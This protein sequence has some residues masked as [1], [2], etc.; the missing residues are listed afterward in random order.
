MAYLVSLTIALRLNKELTS[1]LLPLVV[2][3]GNIVKEGIKKPSNQAQMDAVL[4]F[5][6][7]LE[8]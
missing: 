7:L 8:G 5:R 4:A 2:S 3:L 1:E 6:L